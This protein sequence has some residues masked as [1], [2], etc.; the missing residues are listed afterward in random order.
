MRH[1]RTKSRGTDHEAFRHDSAS[2]NG[3][4]DSGKVPDPKEP[5]IENEAERTGPEVHINNPDWLAVIGSQTLPVLS[6]TPR[7]ITRKADG[8][9]MDCYFVDLARLSDVQKGGILMGFSLMTHRTTSSIWEEAQR[10][11]LPIPVS[12]CTPLL[13]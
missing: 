5:S 4:R 13:S 10:N 12:D 11:G 2:Q 1:A 9:P 6:F 7:S 8:K 3:A